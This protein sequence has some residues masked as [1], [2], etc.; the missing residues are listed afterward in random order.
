M[1]RRILTPPHHRLERWTLPVELLARRPWPTLLHSVDHVGPAWGP[2]RSVV[3]LHDLAF[4][5]YPE[6]H[7]SASRGYYAATGE[8]ARRAERVVAVSQRTASDA[9]RLLGLD[10]ARVRVVHE[11]AAPV[12]T[13]RRPEE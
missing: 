7:T 2:W 13:P 3:T 1:Q 11:A 4:L 8:S 9:V 5:L 6:T 10:P 12:F